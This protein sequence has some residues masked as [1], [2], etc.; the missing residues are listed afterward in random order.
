MARAYFF[1]RRCSLGGRGSCSRQ[2]GIFNFSVDGCSITQG[3]LP[4]C[5]S[6]LLVS[7]PKKKEHKTL[8]LTPSRF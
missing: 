6:G 2:L 1:V 4:H 5:F 8:L 7:F 3:V